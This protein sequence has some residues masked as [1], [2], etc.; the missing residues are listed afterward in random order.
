MPPVL[1]SSLYDYHNHYGVNFFVSQQ[2]FAVDS[3]IFNGHIEKLK[4]MKNYLNLKPLR[5]FLT[6][7]GIITFKD[8]AHLKKLLITWNIGCKIIFIIWE[9]LWKDLRRKKLALALSLKFLRLFSRARWFF[10]L[11]FNQKFLCHVPHFIYVKF[12]LSARFIVNF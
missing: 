7:F 8:Q 1:F 3:E 5:S 10:L 2:F 11:I 12:Q 6:S 9:V 4:E